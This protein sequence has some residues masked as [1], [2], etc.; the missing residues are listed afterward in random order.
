M[1]PHWARAVAVLLALLAS[2]A[3]RLALCAAELPVGSGSSAEQRAALAKLSDQVET[4]SEENARLRALTKLGKSDATVLELLSQIR[5][6]KAQITSLHVY[7]KPDQRASRS[8]EVSPKGVVASVLVPERVVLISRGRECGILEGAVLKLG[9]DGVLAR[10]V[11]SRP[12]VSAAAVENSYKGKL[13]DLVGCT[14]E[15]S[16]R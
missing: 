9:G 2:G 1:M 7:S 16:A 5:E 11:E 10:V 4:M 13:A 3:N 8:G 14:A 12:N 6:L 15:L